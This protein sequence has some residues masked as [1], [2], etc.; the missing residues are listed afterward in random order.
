MTSSKFIPAADSKYPL[1]A[2]MDCSDEPNNLKPVVDLIVQE[3]EERLLC[4]ESDKP[5]VFIYGELHDRL[6]DPLVQKLVVKTLHEKGIKLRVCLEDPSD[7]YLAKPNIAESKKWFPIDFNFEVMN[8]LRNTFQLIKE[9][10]NVDYRFAGASH[11]SF[12]SALLKMGIPVSMI[13]FPRVETEDLELDI[14]KLETITPASLKFLW[15]KNAHFIKDTEDP[16]LTNSH[17]GMRKRNIHEVQEITEIAALDTDIEVIF[18]SAGLNHVFKDY[19]YSLHNLLKL[20]GFDVLA[21]MMTSEGLQD[22][23]EDLSYGMEQISA[24]IHPSFYA[25]LIAVDNVAEN[26]IEIPYDVRY[27][28]QNVEDDGQAA[29]EAQQIVDSLDQKE[30]E[31]ASRILKNSGFDN[32]WFRLDE[33][34]MDDLFKAQMSEEQRLETL[35]QERRKSGIPEFLTGLS[36]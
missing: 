29:Y 12:H 4:K 17:D 31:I 33:E 18:V 21:A 1:C 23:N 6:Q 16:V 5:L 25:D 30:E 19:A 7:K 3:I 24:D 34:T 27:A 10:L 13:D 32:L 20:S 2:T 26:F 14:D 15:R 22:R 8:G 36:L 9:I 28:I 11:R 35:A